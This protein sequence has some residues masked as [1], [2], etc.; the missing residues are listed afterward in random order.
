[1]KLFRTDRLTILATILLVVPAVR[2]A[3]TEWKSTRKPACRWEGEKIDW[4][5]AVGHLYQ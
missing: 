5:L 4:P 1:M 3:S 2:K